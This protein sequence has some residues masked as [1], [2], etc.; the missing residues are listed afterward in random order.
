MSV[1]DSRDVQGC[2]C[3]YTAGARLVA[4]LLLF[5]F[6][7]FQGWHLALVPGHPPLFL[8]TALHHPTSQTRAFKGTEI[9][10][11][12]L[13]FWGILNLLTILYLSHQFKN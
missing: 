6:I 5:F 13:S 7:P 10:L 12:P 2:S 4:Q 3:G 1:W 9:C 8:P 11:L